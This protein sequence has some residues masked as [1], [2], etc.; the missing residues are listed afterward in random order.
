MYSENNFNSKLFNKNSIEDFK[1]WKN[2]KK[3]DNK[4]SSNDIEKY[5]EQ[6]RNEEKDIYND[7]NNKV[8]TN[9]K[10]KEITQFLK[11]T[12]NIIEEETVTEEIINVTLNNVN[13]EQITNVRKRDI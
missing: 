4:L 7:V 13:T 2:T 3:N 6:R 1:K 9:A 10:K 5:L 12:K 11:T 8:R